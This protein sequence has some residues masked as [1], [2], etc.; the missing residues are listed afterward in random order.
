MFNFKKR[1]GLS[2][3][4]WHKWLVTLTVKSS[5]F[6]SLID[7]PE[8]KMLEMRPKQDQ[9]L[10]FSFKYNQASVKTLEE[11]PRWFYRTRMFLSPTNDKLLQ[12][13][14]IRTLEI[15]NNFGL[16]WQDALLHTC[17][18]KN[19]LLLVLLGCVR[20]C[21]Q[22]IEYKFFPSCKNRQELVIIVLQQN[23]IMF[24][25]HKICCLHHC[26]LLCFTF[27][28]TLSPKFWNIRAQQDR[29]WWSPHHVAYK[30]LLLWGSPGSCSLI[31]S[32]D[33]WW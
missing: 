28:T 27:H 26:C 1:L 18:L 8:W 13:Q 9:G 30:R 33:C 19:R 4:R 14:A 23:N 24:D 17:L 3:S 22:F 29:S 16:P 32:C 11:P 31:F 10:E 12:Y 5:I 2:W 25:Q 7:Q 6:E 15:I 21:D 20:L